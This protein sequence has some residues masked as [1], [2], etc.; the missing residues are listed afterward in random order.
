MSYVNSEEQLIWGVIGAGGVLT[1]LPVLILAF[2]LNRFLLQGLT[3][4]AVK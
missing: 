2:A 4:G 1:I 3:A